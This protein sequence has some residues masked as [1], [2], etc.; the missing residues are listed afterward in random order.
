MEHHIRLHLNNIL[1]TPNI[2]NNLIYVRPFV[3]DNSCTVEFNAFGFYVKD[4]LTRR[5]LLRCDSIGDLYPVMKPSTIPHAFLAS[6]YT[7]HQRL[8]H[9]RS[10]VLRH[11]LFSNSILCNKE[12]SPVL[13]HACQFGK[14]V[15]LLFCDHGGEFDNH[16]FHKLFV[17]NGIQFRFSCPCTSQQN[18]ESGRMI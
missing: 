3:R 10:E 11:V 5:V 18:G 8:G 6:Q 2:V 14:H 1:I 4:F 7:W 9:P 13:C 12:A 15:R 17:D 16:A